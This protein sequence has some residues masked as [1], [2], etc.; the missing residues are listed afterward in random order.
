[1]RSGDEGKKTHAADR[2]RR[3]RKNIG[4]D[5]RRRDETDRNERDEPRVVRREPQER[6]DGPNAREN[7]RISLPKKIEERRD[8]K[9][10]ALADEA[11]N[12]KRERIENRKVKRAERAQTNP[13]RAEKP[14]RRIRPKKIQRA[15]RARDVRDTVFGHRRMRTFCFADQ[16]L[17]PPGVVWSPAPAPNANA[18]TCAA[19][20]SLVFAKK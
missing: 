9:N 4:D 13:T 18:T 1:M 2:V 12:L 15:R 17:L 14:R 20:S 10:S 7:R 5:E 19:A 11:A 6:R 16:I 8:R 3:A